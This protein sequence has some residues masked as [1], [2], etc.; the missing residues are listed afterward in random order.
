MEEEKK[1]NNTKYILTNSNEEAR[2][3][4]LSILELPPLTQKYLFF[5]SS[6]GSSRVSNLSY[7]ATVIV[8]NEEK[9]HVINRTYKLM[10]NNSGKLFIK[11]NNPNIGV[12]Y[13]KKGRSSSRVSVWGFKS[14]FD[15]F[16]H[17]DEFDL[18]VDNVNPD[19]KELLKD[20]IVKQILT[21]GLFGS[22]LAG[23]ITS[24][25]EAMSYRITYALR[26]MGLKKT[27]GEALYYF[28]K[29]IG[30]RFNA[31][32]LLYSSLD[33]R[34]VVDTFN[35]NWEYK[36]YQEKLMKNI[37]THGHQLV[38]ICPRVNE[39]IDWVNPDFN[40]G[41]FLERISRKEKRIKDMLQL[42]DG[43]PVLKRKAGPTNYSVWDLANSIPLKASK[44]VGAF[45]LD[46][47]RYIVL[48]HL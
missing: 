4:M 11:S 10:I 44:N 20:T 36:G 21:K 42:W 16:K 3:R 7:N 38:N 2:Q 9:T 25:N 1:A 35:P 14:N 8:D 24:I 6:S 32:V 13:Y 46:P 28:Y 29:K 17:T 43:G 18:L 47:T 26:G 45:V 39:K 15:Q 12:T 5:E 31:D 23:K 30:N 34:A 27:D 41:A 48:S 33:A 40:P 22:I 19:C 37:K